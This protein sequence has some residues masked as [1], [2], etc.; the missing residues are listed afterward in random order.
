MA[1]AMA[2]EEVAPLLVPP[3]YERPSSLKAP[4]ATPLIV[5][6][7][8]V[9]LR[10]EVDVAVDATAWPESP[11]SEFLAP[12]IATAMD[13]PEFAPPWKVLLENEPSSRFEPL[14]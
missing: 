13:W 4:I 3:T 14:N 5:V 1:L 6:V 2:S 12:D 10:A 9:K 7:V 8:A 11:R